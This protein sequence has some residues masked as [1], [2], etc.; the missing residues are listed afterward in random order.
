[1]DENICNQLSGDIAEDVVWRGRMSARF[2]SLNLPS[3]PS[4]ENV[5]RVLK[6]KRKW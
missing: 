3:K 5:I 6:E 1:M 4:K 2:N